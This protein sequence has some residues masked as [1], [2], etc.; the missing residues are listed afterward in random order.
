MHAEFG[1]EYGPLG[2]RA[3]QSEQQVITRALELRAQGHSYRIVAARMNVE[4]Y[5]SRGGGKI[6]ATQVRRWVQRSRAG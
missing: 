1:W 2:W 4:G 5:E 3:V 6:H